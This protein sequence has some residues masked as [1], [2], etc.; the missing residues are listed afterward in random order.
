MSPKPLISAFA[1]LALSIM[2]GSGVGALLP[3]PSILTEEAAHL[4]YTLAI[5][6][7]VFGWLVFGIYQEYDQNE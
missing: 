5:G 3:V 6:S 2:I 4:A 1:L 7:G